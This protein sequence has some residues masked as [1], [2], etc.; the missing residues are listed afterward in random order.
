M[1]HA[2][3]QIR[4]ALVTALPGLSTTGSRIF[5][6]RLYP[7]T[8]ADLPG[9]RIFTDA[10]AV[11][12]QSMHTPHMQGHALTV[13]VECCAKA[14]T[15]LD[16]TVDQIQL[17]VEEALADGLTVGG[18]WLQPVL[19]ASQY[20]DEPGGTAVGVKRLEFSLTYQTL[21]DAPDVIL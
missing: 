17:E 12:A 16:A 8:D 21:N 11:D 13:V 4:A 15:A 20:T 6:N 14:N 10:D 2:H 18:I 5:A 1:A 9:L 3:T 7:L 19:T